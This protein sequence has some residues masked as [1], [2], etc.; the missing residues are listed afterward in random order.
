MPA[1]SDQSFTPKA[2][3]RMALL[4]LALLGVLGSVV[5]AYFAYQ[6]QVEDPRMLRN[7]FDDPPG[8][9]GLSSVRVSA[10]GERAVP[11]L[12]EDLQSND[13]ER[14]AKAMELLGPIDD[15]RVVPALAMFVKSP[16]VSSQLAGIAGLARTGRAE[17]AAY[18]WPLAASR[19]DM[20]RNRALVGLGLCGG[21]ADQAK[22]LAEIK[23]YGDSDRYLA[24]WAVGHMQRRFDAETAGRKG[25]VPPAP[26]PGEESEIAKIQAN[27]D[28]TLGQ[29]DKG[30]ELLEAGKKLAELTDCDFGRGDFGHQIALQVIA[31]GGPRQ[32]RG[33]RQSD[34][35]RP[36]GPALQLNKPVRETPPLP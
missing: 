13:A 7:R 23:N 35:V 6:H 25:P 28:E 9:Q 2:Y 16:D 30:G 11:T 20:V 34:P 14:R 21:K 17:A 26:D 22:L 15:P 8:Q 5:F 19:D 33:M 29:I 24:A 31:I 1:L 3:A 4:A 18:L 36:A 10:M 27:V 32:W 12:I